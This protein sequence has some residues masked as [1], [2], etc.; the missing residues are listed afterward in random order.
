MSSIA[1]AVREAALGTTRYV[2]AALACAI[3]ALA[4]ALAAGIWYSAPAS[5][6]DTHR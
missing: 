3:M 1:S 4:I 5:A 2:G 6:Q